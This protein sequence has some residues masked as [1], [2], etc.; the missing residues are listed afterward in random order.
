MSSPEDP[1]AVAGT[2]PAVRPGVVPAPRGPRDRCDPWLRLEAEGVVTFP[3]AGQPG[4]GRT[5]FLRRQP[6]RIRDGRFEGGYASVFELICP[7][8]G[9]HP[10]LDYSQIPPR[11][12]HIRGPYRLDAGLAAYH[13]HLGPPSRPH[14][15]EPGA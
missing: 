7:S 8:C 15:D 4:H 5:A 6:S 10:Y 12:Q 1:D 3:L 9:D 11:L 14:E 2:R 13:E